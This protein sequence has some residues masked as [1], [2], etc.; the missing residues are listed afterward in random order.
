MRDLSVD[1][2][3][4]AAGDLEAVA[5]LWMSMVE[6]HRMIAGADLPIR[7]SADAWALRQQEYRAWLRDDSGLLLLARI[8]GTDEL[9]GYAFCRVIASGPTFDFGERGDVESL[10]VAPEARGAGIGTALLRASRHQLKLRGC[11]YWTVSV[12]EANNGAVQLYERVGFRPWLRELAA[13]LD[14]SWPAS[15]RR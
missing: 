2:T 15:R 13:P 5:P 3:L 10:V 4:G 14:E 7:A 11:A 9:A 12:M 6:H 1:I 8:R